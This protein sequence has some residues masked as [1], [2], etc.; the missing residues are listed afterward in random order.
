[1]A[2]YIYSR[3]RSGLDSFCSFVWLFV[4]CS[5]CKESFTQLAKESLCDP[6]EGS[7]AQVHIDH[8]KCHCSATKFVRINNAAERKE[9]IIQTSCASPRTH[10]RANWQVR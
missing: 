1:M 3:K 10:H 7:P 4:L 5:G 8:L 2:S 9:K 6:A